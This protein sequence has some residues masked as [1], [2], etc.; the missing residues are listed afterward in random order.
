LRQEV[1]DYL[2]EFLPR[3]R[4]HRI[5]TLEQLS[6]SDGTN[7]FDV[8][9][10]FIRAKTMVVIALVCGGLAQTLCGALILGLDVNQ[11]GTA[12][13]SVLG[14]QISASGFGGIVMATSVMWGYF[15]YLARPKYSRVSESTRTT[16]PD[17][18]I[19]THE[20]SSS[21]Q[22]R[23]APTPLRPGVQATVREH[24]AAHS[25]IAPESSSA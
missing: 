10:A 18:T 9:I 11:Q 14:M 3:T 19:E 5:I 1:G 16:R 21:T 13:L 12:T 4:A 7:S 15:A 23:A 25:P 22:I 2:R 24:P 17:G 6:M 8:D 20:H